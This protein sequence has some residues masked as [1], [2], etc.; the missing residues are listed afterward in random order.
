MADTCLTR[1]G[2]GSD[3]GFGSLAV[4]RGSSALECGTPGC[5]PLPALAKLGISTTRVGLM[6]IF[7][8]HGAS[9]FWKGIDS[10]KIMRPK[11]GQPACGAR[12]ARYLG[13]I[14]PGTLGFRRLE[15][16]AASDSEYAPY[17]AHFLDAVNY[18]AL[19]CPFISTGN[20]GLSVM[21]EGAAASSHFD[22]PDRPNTVRGLSVRLACGATG[23]AAAVTE[24]RA[25]VLC[26]TLHLAHEGRAGLVDGSASEQIEHTAGAMFMDPTASGETTLE[27]VPTDTQRQASDALRDFAHGLVVLVRL[28][29][30]RKRSA[31][32]GGVLHDHARDTFEATVFQQTI[33]DFNRRSSTLYPQGLALAQTFEPFELP[34]AFQQ[35]D[36]ETAKLVDCFA[37]GQVPP[38][39]QRVAP[40][41]RSADGLVFDCVCGTVRVRARQDARVAD[42]NG[43]PVWC[44]LAVAHR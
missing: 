13:D 9:M 12:Y 29:H 40:L 21:L 8:G 24:A 10:I 26:F 23:A 18:L 38:R 20:L 31:L 42:G 3:D 32:S 27:F 39:S 25:H 41:Q 15:A 6:S 33:V 43:R 16:L 2:G 11:I 37:K 19:R 30:Q 36:D 44:P 17:V 35:E 7:D 14:S 34:T 1:S 4:A 22:K 28:Y 5:I